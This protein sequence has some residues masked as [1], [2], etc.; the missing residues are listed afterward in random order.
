M[1]GLNAG[2]REGLAALKGVL[3][4]SPRA[5]SPY[6]LNLSIKGIRPE[7]LVHAMSE[8]AIYLSTASACSSK[9]GVPSAAVLAMCGDEERARQSVRLSLSHLSSGD[10]C[11]RFLE[12]LTTALNTLR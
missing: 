7:S 2:L 10:E 8:Q 12:H 4:N 9:D 6:I 5:G 11:T 1:A 3:V